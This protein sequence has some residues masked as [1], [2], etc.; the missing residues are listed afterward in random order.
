MAQGTFS[1]SLIKSFLF[2]RRKKVWPYGK[3][4]V[5]IKNSDDKL[6][7]VAIAKIIDSIKQSLKTRLR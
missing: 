3:S 6:M 4:F 1:L 2:Q 7:K 5:I